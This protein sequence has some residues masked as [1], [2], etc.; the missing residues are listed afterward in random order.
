MTQ[1]IF[2]PNNYESIT[3]PGVYHDA[4]NM[5]VEL[6]IL[7]RDITVDE[8]PW[9]GCGGREWGRLVAAIKRLIKDFE[10]M[11]DQLA[12]YIFKCSPQDINSTEFAKMAVVA[13]KLLRSYD[14]EQLVVLYSER[15]ENAKPSVLQQAGY[16]RIK[17]KTLTDLLKELED[18]QT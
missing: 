16:K 18:G 13:K 7:N 15:R 5:L 10:I 12:Y 17:E 3:T 11:P 4:A 8:Y 1:E 2:S 6:L 14:I 9:R